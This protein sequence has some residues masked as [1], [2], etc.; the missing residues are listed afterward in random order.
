MSYYMSLAS[1]MNS[2]ALGWLH[3]PRPFLPP[4]PPPPS[5]PLPSLQARVE[6]V[7]AAGGAAVIAG[8]FNICPSPLDSCNPERFSTRTSSV[9]STRGAGSGEGE[10]EEEDDNEGDP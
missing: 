1:L 4:R 2:L 10:E 3:L 7:I 6:S 9:S 8:D 5:L